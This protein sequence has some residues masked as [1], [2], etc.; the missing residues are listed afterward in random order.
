VSAAVVLGILLASPSA[1]AQPGASPSEDDAS[2]RTPFVEVRLT[3]SEPASVLLVPRRFRR[4]LSIELDNAGHVAA[5][6]EG[7]LNDHVAYVWIDL[8]EPRRVRVQTRVGGGAVATRKFSLREGLRA[9]V[10]ARL[11]AIATSEMVRAQARPSRVHKPQPPKPPTPEEVERAT[12]DDPAVMLAGHVR[13]AWLPS[14]QGVLGGSGLALSF[15]LAGFRQRLSVAWLGGDSAAGP[16]RW[17]STGLGV[18]RT[19]WIRDGWRFDVG[20]GADAAL[21][22]LR[23]VTSLDGRPGQRASWSAQTAALFRV[24]RGLSPSTWLGL[25]VEPGVMLR[26]V[27]Y[28]HRDR[29]SGSVEGL[30]LGVNL[31]LQLERRLSS[32]GKASLRTTSAAAAN[33]IAAGTSTIDGWM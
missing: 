18:S 6:N 21:L 22:H 14:V 30:F 11:V 32:D 29:S 1:H 4:Y 8:P 7:P 23:D 27:P 9:D 2:A 19:V 31:S 3:L 26:S 15:R 10:A 33:P 25:S 17:T 28:L 20:A 12:R 16:L 5:R 24:E 13:G